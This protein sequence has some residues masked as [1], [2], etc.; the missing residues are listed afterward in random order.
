VR[1]PVC[2]MA[3]PLEGVACRRGGAQSAVGVVVVPP[4]GERIEP[5]RCVGVG[6][7]C[8]RRSCRVVDDGRP[9][10]PACVVAMNED[11]CC[12]SLRRCHIP[13]KLPAVGHAGGKGGKLQGTRRRAAAVC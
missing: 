2:Q 8:A 1:D 5:S 9:R 4:A 11:V 10:H 6:A 13:A 3:Q 12:S 7:S